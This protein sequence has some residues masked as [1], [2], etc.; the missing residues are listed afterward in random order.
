MILGLRLSPDTPPRTLS[1]PKK[2]KLTTPP[3]ARRKKLKG[4]QKGRKK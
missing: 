1:P 3:V 2:S 4:Y